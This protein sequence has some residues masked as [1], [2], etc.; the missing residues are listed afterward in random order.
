MK[1]ETNL[2]EFYT[3]NQ[4]HWDE[5]VEPHV[6]SDLY[7]MSEFL[8]GKNKLHK[9]EREELGDISGKNILHLQ[10]HFGMDTLSLE[11]LGASVTGVDFSEKAIS[12]ANELRDKLNMKSKFILSDVY[13]LPEKLDE[14]F[15]IV[16]TTYGVLLWLHDI[17]KWAE[18]VSHFLKPGGYLYLAESHPAANI[19]EFIDGELKIQYSYFYKKEPTKFEDEGDYANFSKKYENKVTY[20]WD[21]S[22]SDIFNA[23][24]RNGMSIGY[25]N[26]H[27]FTVWQ[28]FPFLVKDKD[29]LFQFPEGYTNTLP[30][31][32]SLKAYKQ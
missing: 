21:H 9:L 5:S 6:G 2:N 11:M 32:F 28:K 17:N 1:N 8:A 27:P 19:F 12:T 26:E 24:I 25:F 23:L 31:L 3:A 16:Y 14:K 22:L 15:D 30:L 20:E 13:S 18:T 10:C 4:K 29:G 7:G